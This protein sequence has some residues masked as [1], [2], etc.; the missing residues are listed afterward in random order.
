MPAS[1][2][3][4][5]HSRAIERV[6]SE[7]RGYSDLA[8]KIRSFRITD[9]E[10]ADFCLQ[11]AVMLQARISIQRALEALAGQATNRR[12]KVVIE[13]LR[14]EIQ[15]GHPL[16]RALS[17]QPGVFDNLF[18]VTCEVGEESG[19]LAEVLN[20]LAEHLEK[21]SALR[22][23][24][25]QALTYPA[26]VMAVAT[27]VV[28]FLLLVVVP[29]FG[30]MFKNFR[31]ELP[32]STGIILQLS[33]FFK[34]YGIYLAGTAGVGLYVFRQALR[35][36]AVRDGGER[37]LLTVPLI[38]DILLKSYVARVCRTLGTMLQSHV[39]LLDALEVTARLVTN[40]DIRED[41]RK[42]TKQVKLGQAL[43]E[44][45]VESKLFPPMVSQMIAVGEETSDIDGM[46]LKVAQYYEKEL[47][48][49][50]DTIST[51]IEPVLILFLGLIVAAILVSL[52]L[53][54][55]ELVNVVGAGQ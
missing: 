48:H 4:V 52:Y 7:R 47:D 21:L 49:K 40:A 32:A 53:P 19:R 31:L 26:L 6:Q 3:Q 2:G 38:G 39:S 22:R 8:G 46:L 42:I 28:L 13:S 25:V 30:E 37:F 23:K 14:K 29:M 45:V 34:G 27:L 9:R 43:A 24:V 44:P 51:V 33:E 12:M 17:L 36:Q 41:I 50:V 15:R 20:H 10:K 35:K 5:V 11:L 55:F 1:E 54:M 18:I 16:N